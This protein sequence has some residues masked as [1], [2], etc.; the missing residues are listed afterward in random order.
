MTWL[1]YRGDLHLFWDGMDDGGGFST[2]CI[3]Y[4]HTQSWLTLVILWTV[5]HL[6]P[7][8]VGIFQARILK[9]IVIASSRDLSD[10]GI[11]LVSPASP[12]LADGFFTTKAP[13]E[14]AGDTEWQFIIQTPVL[15]VLPLLGGCRMPVGLKGLLLPHSIDWALPSTVVCWHTAFLHTL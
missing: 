13:G 2:V 9:W 10:P 15:G 4:V 6:A 11:E 3:A 1:L 14:P 7:P 8:S 5:A 12:A